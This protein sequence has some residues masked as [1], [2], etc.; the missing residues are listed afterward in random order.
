[1]GAPVAKEACRVSTCL[2]PI[3]VDVVAVVIVV[4]ALRVIVVI[5]AH[6]VAAIAMTEPHGMAH[7]VAGSPLP[8]I[9]ASDLGAVEIKPRSL[10]IG[11]V[12]KAG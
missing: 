4:D 5:A 6:A 3:V 7:L 10:A 11:E 9:E 12:V 2:E 1:M 8:V